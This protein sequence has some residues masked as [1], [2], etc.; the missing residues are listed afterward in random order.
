MRPI[1]PNTQP[2]HSVSVSYDATPKDAVLST[3]IDIFRRAFAGDMDSWSELQTQYNQLMRHWIGQQRI[4]DAEEILQEAWLAFARYAPRQPNL[5][6]AESP[7]RVLAYLRT[8]VKTAIVTL[9]RREQRHMMMT[10]LDPSDDVASVANVDHTVVQQLT[11]HERVQ[12]L[13]SSDDERLLFHLRFVHGMKP[14]SIVDTY[15]ERFP[16]V[17][18]VYTLIA[19]L[20]RRLRA[21]RLLQDLR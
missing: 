14:Q 1:Q 4:I 15:P 16:E 21:D 18:Q 5:V 20:V 12:Q 13:L 11:I 9:Y 8:C 17:Q 2:K 3:E 6:E 7:A 19:Q 10:Y